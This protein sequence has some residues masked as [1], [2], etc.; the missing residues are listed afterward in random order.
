MKNHYK[1]IIEKNVS[2]YKIRLI[3]KFKLFI[4]LVLSFSYC[5]AQT[6]TDE[7]QKL[8]IETFNIYLKSDPKKTQKSEDLYRLMIKHSDISEEE[9]TKSILWYKQNLVHVDSVMNTCVSL[10]KYHE[11]E[12]LIKLLEVERTNIIS[13]PNNDI[14]NECQL[15]SVMALLYSQLIADDTEFY[16]KLEP[17]A[18]WS[19]MHIEAIQGQ[20]GKEHPL[21]KQVL[22]ELKEIY[23]RLGKNDKVKE[24]DLLISK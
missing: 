5:T 6:F 3:M 19:K 22:N 9:K 4:F 2:Y 12:K 20:N 18:E 15:H 24:I 11:Y 7:H 13:H 17:L 8:C 10:A 16:S 1:F 21:Y 14:Y 23:S